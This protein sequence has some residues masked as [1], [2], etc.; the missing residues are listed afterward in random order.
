MVAADS[1]LSPASERTL[2]A[3]PRRRPRAALNT[4]EARG[5]RAPTHHKAGELRSAGGRARITFL[6]TENQQT[7]PA[8]DGSAR[9][10]K[11]ARARRRSGVVTGVCEETNGKNR[12]F[13]DARIADPDR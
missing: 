3:E 12:E 4:R 1:L 8:R 6:G 11:N 2:R 9:A 13:A 7:G 10:Q 5:V